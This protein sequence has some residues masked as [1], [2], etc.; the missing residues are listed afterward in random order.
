M[1]ANPNVVGTIKELP[2]CFWCEQTVLPDICIILKDNQGTDRYMH[3]ECFRIAG[4]LLQNG[5]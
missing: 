2:I 5:R 3:L 1:A 4:Q